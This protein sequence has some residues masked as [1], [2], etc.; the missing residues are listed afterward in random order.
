MQPKLM[1]FAELRHLRDGV[2]TRGTGRADGSGHEKG[3]MARFAIRLYRMGQRVGPQAIIRIHFDQ[4]DVFL[5]DA[6]RQT[7]FGDGTVCLFRG[8]SAQSWQIT[9]AHPLAANVAIQRFAGGGHR[10]K[11][12]NGSGIRDDPLERIRQL[13]PA[14]QPIGNPSFQLR[15]GWRG[16]PEHAV[17]VERRRQ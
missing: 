6:Q 10:Q 7:R 5:P 12:G 8:I 17:H 1:A 13:E 14:P 3:Q 16:Q 11:R 2:H 15:G 9:T 4:A